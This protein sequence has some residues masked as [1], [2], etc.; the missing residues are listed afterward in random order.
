MGIL[1]SADLYM[2]LLRSDETEPPQESGYARALLKDVPWEKISDIPWD[3]DIVFPDVTAPGYGEVV[4]MAL[5]QQ[6]AGGKP[7]CVWPLPVAVNAHQDT[8]PVIH[9][10][11]LYL[12]VDVKARIILNSS[13]LCGAGG[14]R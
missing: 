2:G 8:V 7:L 14:I 11:R 1:K 13:D 3:R 6:P 4:Y 10:G 9:E 5:Y 12:G